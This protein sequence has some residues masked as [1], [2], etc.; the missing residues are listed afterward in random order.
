MSRQHPTF[1]SSI[2]DWH[3]PDVQWRQ[4]ARDR[5][6]KSD[7]HFDGEDI[8]DQEGTLVGWGRLLGVDEAAELYGNQPWF[9][10]ED[11][12]KYRGRPVGYL[13]W[14]HI[15]SA[16]EFAEAVSWGFRGRI[17]RADRENAIDPIIERSY[18]L[19]DLTSKF[20]FEDGDYFLSRTDEEYCAAMTNR[21]CAELAKVGY[22]SFLGFSPD[23]I[24]NP[25]RLHAA[26]EVKTKPIEPTANLLRPLSV[27]L[28][29]LD[30]RVYKNHADFWEWP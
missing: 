12:G 6:A 5:L 18:S 28:L 16:V 23:T 19:V 15:D 10:S 17:G 29:V 13:A 25:L 14:E 7:L 8:N 11:Y 30:S 4:F 22:Q 2:L 3:L 24:H 26:L 9:R 21:I 27:K 1:V 20:G